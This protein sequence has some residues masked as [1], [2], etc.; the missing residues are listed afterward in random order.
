MTKWE[1]SLI[2]LGLTVDV[3]GEHFILQLRVMKQLN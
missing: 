2:Y 1:I 3:D